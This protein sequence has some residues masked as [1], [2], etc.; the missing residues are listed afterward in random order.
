MDEPLRCSCN[1]YF[2]AN[3]TKVNIYVAVYEVPGTMNSN[4][5]LSN[6]LPYRLAFVSERISRR[7]AVEYG[8]SHG[9]SMPE[10]R[11]L[12]HLQRVGTASVRDIQGYT[13]LEKSRVSRVVGRLIEKGWVSKNAS[14][15]DARLVEIALTSKG[16]QTIDEV[17]PLATDFE[18]QLLKGLSAPQIKDLS[19]TIERLHRILDDDPDA[20]P[21]KKIDR[22]TSG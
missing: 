17:V 4:F 5:D 14:A 6:F 20:Q 9:L 16:R 15:D 19:K 18:D 10:W 2:V 21:R 22:M 8:R 12:V 7:L 13:N 1:E 3:A 11:V